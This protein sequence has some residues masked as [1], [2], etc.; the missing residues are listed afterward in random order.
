M[1]T[2]MR[3]ITKNN[4]VIYGRTLEFG[5]DL[6]SSIMVIPRNFKF[7]ATAAENI[8]GITWKSSYATVGANGVHQNHFIDGMNEKGLAGGIFYFPHFSQFQKVTIDDYEKTIAPWELLTFLLTTCESVAQVK[9]IVPHIIVGAIVFAGWKIVP[10]V[11]FILH[12]NTGKSIVIEYIQEK[13]YLYDN[14]CGVITNAPNFDWHIT[15][16]NNYISMTPLNN[17]EYFISQGSG[18]LGLP[19]D[20]TSPSRFVR[21]YAY[22]KAVVDLNNEAETIDTL[23]HV[24]NLFSIP[25]GIVQEKIATARA[26]DYT[27]WASG[28]D[29]YNKKYYYTTYTCR[30]IKMIDL[31]EQELNSENILI[32]ELMK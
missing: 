15:N 13:L 28:S 27:Q 30:E 2:G 3:F 20:F 22:S 5:Q 10:P 16:L 17:P 1:C 29:L 8:K 23:F 21:A 19:G 31:M 9:E 26:Y 6:E 7:E 4:R 11:H 12:D 14:E 32:K 25:R 18:M 24:L